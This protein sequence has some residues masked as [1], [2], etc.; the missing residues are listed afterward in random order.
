MPR[1]IYVVATMDT[2]GHEAQ[3]VADAISKAGGSALTV[4]VGTQGEPVVPPGIS[5]EI[6]ADCHPAGRSAVLGKQDRGDGA[7]RDE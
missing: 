1:A 3:F 6:V 2:K 5:R 7:D 4:D